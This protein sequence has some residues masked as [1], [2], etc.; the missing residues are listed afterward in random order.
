MTINPYFEFLTKDVAKPA[1]ALIVWD[2]DL[3]IQN[4]MDTTTT[5][6]Q[7]G[8]MSELWERT[9]GGVLLM[10]GRTHQS[11]EI[12]FG[13]EYAGVYEHGSIA[14]FGHGH[15]ITWLAPEVDSLKMG[16]LA[17]QGITKDGSIRI[18]ASPQDIRDNSFEGSK[19]RAVYVEIKNASIALVHTTNGDHSH[20]D[21]MREVLEPLGDKILKNMGLSDTHKV[22]HGSDAVELVPK[23][24]SPDHKAGLVLP[25]AEV[26]RINREGLSKETAVH[27][28][29]A[30]FEGRRML[31]TGD[32][33]PDL[34]AMIVAK[35]NYDGRGVFV[36]NGHTLTEIYNDPKEVAQKKAE[37]CQEALIGVTGHFSKSWGL[38]EDTVLRLRDLAPIVKITPSN[39]VDVMGKPPAP[40]APPTL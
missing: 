11:G 9:D 24:P 6:E 31:F 26:E 2:V 4:S 19:D 3:A 28:F 8:H 17:T 16:E 36:S 27:N 40:P 39:V 21:S 23:G 5:A 12:T 33:K 35:E 37:R 7:R 20:L 14:R 34:D 18:A 38:V 25:K 13:R 30:L 1:K 32:S 10:T 22:K 29:Q 15:K